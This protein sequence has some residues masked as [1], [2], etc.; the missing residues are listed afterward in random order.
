[1]MTAM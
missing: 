1:P